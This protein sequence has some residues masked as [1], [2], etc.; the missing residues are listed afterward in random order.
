MQCGVIENLLR[1]T[2][3]I[4]SRAHSSQLG[5]QYFHKKIVVNFLRVECGVSEDLLRR[6]D[7]VTSDI[8]RWPTPTPPKIVVDF[9]SFINMR[10]FRQD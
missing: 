7:G 8:H 4:T 5:D 6:M 2:A 3:G 9:K 1:R 10:T